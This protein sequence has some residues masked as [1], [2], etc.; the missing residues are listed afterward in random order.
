MLT[1]GKGEGDPW[2][3]RDGRVGQEQI[4]QSV[5]G[6]GRFFKPT[7]FNPFVWTN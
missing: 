5:T 2:N 3:V 7:M 6:E 1:S 4:W